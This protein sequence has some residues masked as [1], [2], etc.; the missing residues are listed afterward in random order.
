VQA[1]VATG[2]GVA[3]ISQMAAREMPGITHRELERPR[4]HRELWAVHTR[5]TRL[6]PLVVEF[7]QLVGQVCGELTDRWAGAPLS[8][9]VAAQS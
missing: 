8:E 9:V 5:D 6:T 7:V 4:L 1:L 3:V 2:L